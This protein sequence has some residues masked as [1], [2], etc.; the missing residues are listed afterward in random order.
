MLLESVAVHFFYREV[1][2]HFRIAKVIADETIKV[3]HAAS[4]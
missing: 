1:P 4:A 2:P 3:F